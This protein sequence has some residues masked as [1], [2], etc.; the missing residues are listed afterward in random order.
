MSWRI[1]IYFDS[2]MSKSINTVVYFDWKTIIYI[3]ACGQCR[4]QFMLPNSRCI[5][6]TTP[7][8]LNRRSCLL[9]ESGNASIPTLDLFSQQMVSTFANLSF[10]CHI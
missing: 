5:F 10:N 2:D 4:T 6:I 9:S 1:F 7:F 8:R 3:Y